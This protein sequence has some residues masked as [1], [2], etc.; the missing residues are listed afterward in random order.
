MQNLQCS[1]NYYLRTFH[2]TDN[3]VITG[4]NGAH[5]AGYSNAMVRG[6][7]IHLQSISFFRSG[8]S[9]YFPNIAGLELT[10]SNVKVI[11]KQDL[12]PFRLL[13]FLV[14][15]G[16]RLESLEIDTFEGNPNIDYVVFANNDLKHLDPRTFD[17]LTRLYYLDVTSNRCINRAASTP[18]QLAEL[19]TE[20]GIKC[21]TVRNQISD[22]I[23]LQDKKIK[24]ADAKLK[25]EIEALKE[26]VMQF[27]ANDSKEYCKTHLKI[28]G[29]CMTIA[30][31]Q[32]V[33]MNRKSRQSLS[34]LNKPEVCSL[35]YYWTVIF[36]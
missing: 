23:N 28:L 22:A 14:M 32:W 31:Q 25:A 3:E 9:Q 12:S 35:T 17:V 8:F 6:L 7:G 21:K 29:K 11:R 33:L 27:V 30:S 34:L 24:N 15:Q 18:Q 4:I 2:C 36:Y 20:I 13:Q 1:D 19:K 26:I 16:N 10:N 5:V